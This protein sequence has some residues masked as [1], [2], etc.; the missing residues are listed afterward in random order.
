MAL[1]KGDPGKQN[2]KKLDADIMNDRP[3]ASTRPVDITPGVGDMGRV[4]FRVPLKLDV[5][6]DRNTYSTIAAVENNPYAQSLRKNAEL[7]EQALQEYGQFLS[8]M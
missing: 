3:L 5:S 6:R 7:D 2:S 4:E 8:Q 1:F